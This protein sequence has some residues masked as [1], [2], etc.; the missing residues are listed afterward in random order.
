MA[1]PT[2]IT[3]AV[4]NWKKEKKTKC[5]QKRVKKLV[6]VRVEQLQALESALR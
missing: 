3:K 2:K 6:Q 1:S 5:R 4:R